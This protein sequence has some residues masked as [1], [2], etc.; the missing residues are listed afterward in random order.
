MSLVW[1]L[2]IVGLF[3]A[4]FFFIKKRLRPAALLQTTISGDLDALGYGSD[5]LVESIQQLFGTTDM[6]QI[7]TG[8]QAM[9]A[10]LEEWR[11]KEV[12]SQPDLAIKLSQL[13]KTITTLTSERDQAQAAGERWQAKAISST[14]EVDGLRQEITKYGKWE[15]VDDEDLAAFFPTVTLSDSQTEEPFLA[16]KRRQRRLT[17]RLSAEGYSILKKILN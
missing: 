6:K 4:A 5:Q 15:I 11:T 12:R 10:E 13:E 3:V 16:S 8:I 14:Q 17:Q 1:L 2:L 7:T 9:Y